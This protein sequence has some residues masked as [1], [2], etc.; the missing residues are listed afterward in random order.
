MDDNLESQLQMLK[1]QILAI[2]SEL[3]RRKHN[4]TT[5][6]HPLLSMDVSC[7]LGPESIISSSKNDS[8]S[9]LSF[10]P[11]TGIYDPLYGS[12]VANDPSAPS[13][14]SSFCYEQ[15]LLSKL[16]EVLGGK[17]P[18]ESEDL[19]TEEDASCDQLLD[20]VQRVLDNE[21]T[22]TKKEHLESSAEY[23]PSDA[24]HE[25]QKSD[26]TIKDLRADSKLADSVISLKYD[27][28]QENRS[29]VIDLSKLHNGT[30]LSPW[31]LPKIEYN[32]ILN[33]EDTFIEVN[34]LRFL[35]CG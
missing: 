29:P 5:P 3:F 28:D 30:A 12:E 32:S 10:Q 33:E 2:E 34:L 14:E 1:N 4:D 11:P 17:E 27:R 25:D 13:L 9:M 22:P 19:E 8:E 21:T 26:C 7:T 31:I 18:I 16:N 15:M 20:L 35:T 24:F 23:F 6:M